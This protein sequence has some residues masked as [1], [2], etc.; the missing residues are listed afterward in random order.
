MG[1]SGAQR[2]YVIVRQG[3]IARI[4]ELLENVS[5]NFMVDALIFPGNKR[6]PRHSQT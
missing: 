1:L 2:N 6:R 4:S 3:A 5:P